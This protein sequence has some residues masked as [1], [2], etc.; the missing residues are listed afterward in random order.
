MMMLGRCLD[1][2]ADYGVTKLLSEV[3]FEVAQEQK[4]LPSLL[5]LDS[6]SFSLSGDYEDA[7][8]DNV[9]SM[10]I[11]IRERFT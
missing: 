10:K 11:Y 2:I 1:K 9:S 6:T 3:A 4:V 8:P 5:H 7:S